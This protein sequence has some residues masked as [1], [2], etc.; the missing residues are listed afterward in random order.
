VAGMGGV[1]KTELA[2]KYAYQH[3]ANYPG[4]ICWFNAR[5][6]NIGVKYSEGIKVLDFR[7]NPKSKI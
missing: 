1:G 6:G 5:Q 2:M 4:G 7:F 3:E